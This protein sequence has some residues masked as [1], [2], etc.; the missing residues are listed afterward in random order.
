MDA[1]KPSK[2][3][4]TIYRINLLLIGLLLLLSV[5]RGLSAEE[6]LL[7]SILLI[8]VLTFVFLIT[9][10]LITFLVLN[11]WGAI[12]YDLYRIRYNI[13]SIV[14]TPLII[15]GIYKMIYIPLP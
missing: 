2:I 8:A 3:F 14:L 4:N 6:D 10:L 15:W 13:V 11:V 5:F 1:R 7:G 9:P 12:K